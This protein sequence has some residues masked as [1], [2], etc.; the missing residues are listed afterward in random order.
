MP[1]FSIVSPVIQNCVLLSSLVTS[2]FFWVKD[3]CLSRISLGF[4]QVYA[5]ND[6]L[7]P[8]FNNLGAASCFFVGRANLQFIRALLLPCLSELYQAGIKWLSINVNRR[9]VK[10]LTEV[11]FFSYNL[12]FSACFSARMVFFSRNKSVGTM[13]RLIFSAKL[14][15]PESDMENKADHLTVY[16]TIHTAGSHK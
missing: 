3:I 15:G 2:F 6:G 11:I 8:L 12:S 1:L 7:V 5:E 10:I 16:K 9:S 4:I 13:F 14:T